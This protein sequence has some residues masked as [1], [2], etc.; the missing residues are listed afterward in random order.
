MSDPKYTVY[1]DLLEELRPYG[2]R[3]VAV[4]KTRTV[5]EIKE[6]IA[7]GQTDF[8]ENYVQELLH[9]QES[10]PEGPL[11][12]FIGHLQSNKVKFLLP[13]IHLIHGVGS[14]SVLK[15]INKRSLDIQI[16]TDILLQVHIAKEESKSGFEPDELLGLIDALMKEPLPG[17]RIRGLMGMAT[18]TEKDDLI[19]AE[20]R[21]LKSLFDQIGHSCIDSFDTLSMGMSSDYKIALD[22]GSNMVRIGS[23]I[24]GPRN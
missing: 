23:K 13:F 16:R 5:E 22:E 11:W 24:F 4:S 3:L 6:L 9:K 18:F 14:M 21:Q 20:F 17:I 7:M 15:E 1:Q 12:H 10:L 19:R 8:G 2:A